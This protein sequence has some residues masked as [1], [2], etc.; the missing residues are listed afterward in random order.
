MRNSWK[1]FAAAAIGLALAGCAST[2]APKVPEDGRVTVT[3][4]PDGT[5]VE[6][7]QSGHAVSTAATLAYQAGQKPILEMEALDGQTIE[8]KGVKRL[9]VYSPQ[10]AGQGAVAFAP[11]PREPSGWEKALHVADRVLDRGL[12]ALGLYYGYRGQVVTA[13][14]NRD[15]QLGQQR[16]TVDVVNGVGSSNAAIAGHIPQPGPQTTINVDGSQGVGI[17]V[18]GTGTGSWERR[19]QCYSGNGAAGGAGTG[20]AGGDTT[21]GPAAPSGAVTCQ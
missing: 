19:I 4:K 16:M 2:K 7:T 21:G 20:G 1:L 17:G 12:Q 10:G 9:A 6:E 3:V 14:A 8:L 15:V 11:P 18:S 13:Q 5:R